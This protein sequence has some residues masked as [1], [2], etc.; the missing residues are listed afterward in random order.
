[1]SLGKLAYYTLFNETKE[2]TLIFD[3]SLARKYLT[4]DDM[5]FTLS[6]GMLTENTSKTLTKKI[7]KVS[8]SHKT[9]HEFFAAIFICSES[10]AQKKVVE[11]CKNVHDIL[12][13]SIICEFVS[14]IN[15]DRMCAISNDLMPV[16]N[17]DKTTRSY[18]KSKRHENF[19]FN[20]LYNIQ[21]MILSCLNEMNESENIQLCL[22]DFFIDENT[23]NEKHSE[24]SGDSESEYYDTDSEFDDDSAYCDE[25]ENTMHH[26]QLKLLFKQNKINIKSLY[27]YSK[28]GNIDLFT[29]T[30]LSHIQ[31]LYYYGD[32]ENEARINLLLSPSLQTLTLR[33]GRLTNDCESL[34]QLH[35]LQYLCIE[36]FTLSHKILELIF[37]FI[38]GQKSMKQLKLH[39]LNCKEHDDQCQRWNLDLSR[40]SHLVDL[41]LKYLPPLKLSITT[42]S[43]VDFVLSMIDL[44]ERSLLLSREML[45]IKR[46]VL[47]FIK[48][49][50][51]GLQNFITI[52]ENLPQSVT[53]KMACVGPE[54]E[55]KI[56]IENIRNSQTFY[57]FYEN[58]KGW[59]NI[60]FLTK[61]PRADYAEM[62]CGHELKLKKSGRSIQNFK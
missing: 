30:N 23:E 8:F 10:D 2:N 29:L 24:L 61:T 21:K 28:R 26:E 44:D 20:T 18:R 58:Y 37:N 59:H 1:M 32:K 60:E 31:K 45:N 25:S 4:Q 22:Q 3:G 9:V 53:V 27:I 43:L 17:E 56:V 35:N 42:P 5:R 12:D 54:S 48:M 52:L 41:H 14:K 19:P 49:P 6:S 46:V 55:C 7:C 62:S 15:S 50:P 13:M 34:A 47:K 36:R 39:D 33:V 11:K 38:S 16:I 57:V 40:H 51:G